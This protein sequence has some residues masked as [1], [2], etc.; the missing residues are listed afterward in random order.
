MADHHT[1]LWAQ[2]KHQR[3]PSPSGR[4]SG[5]QLPPLASLRCLQLTP[6]AVTSNVT[7]ALDLFLALEA[8]KHQ[9]FI[10]RYVVIDTLFMQVLGV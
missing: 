5:I 10:C 3:N 7:T 9:L 1:T 6:T 4:K 2:L 8:T